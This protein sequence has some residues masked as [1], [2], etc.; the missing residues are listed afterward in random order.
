MRARSVFAS[1]VLAAFATTSCSLVR[2]PLIDDPCVA[3]ALP[4]RCVAGRCVAGDGGLRLDAPVGMPDSG[5]VDAPADSASG[6]APVDVGADA[7]S[8]ADGVLSGDESDVDCG[9]ACPSCGACQGCRDSGDCAGGRACR[10]G[11]CEAVLTTVVSSAGER[12]AFVRGDGAVLLAHYAPGTFHSTFDPFVSQVTTVAGGE[13]APPGFA[14][15]PCFAS[16]HLN[17]ADFAPAGRGVEFACGVSEEA[18]SRVSSREL[19]RD[20]SP[21]DHG[22]PHSAGAP[23]WAHISAAGSGLG[24]ARFGVCGTTLDPTVGGV[25]MCTGPRATDASTHIASFTSGPRGSYVGCDGAM[26]AGTACP[27]VWVWLLP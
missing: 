8:C 7:G 19:F 25:G 13:T 22:V 18:A 26:C 23:G 11:R 21:G 2:S 4:D 12:D 17:F 10:T 20:F 6:D 9:G 27:H 14:P 15:D 16:G 24:R 3:C 5:L 1:A